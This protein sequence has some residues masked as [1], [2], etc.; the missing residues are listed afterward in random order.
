V[1]I[2]ESERSGIQGYRVAQIRAVF[3]LPQKAISTLF[4]A[5]VDPPK[6]LAYVEW[7]SEFRHNPEAN[8][9][10]YKIDRSFKD[11]K[12][13]AS[14]VRVSDIERSVFLFPKFGPIAPREWTNSNVLEQ[15]TMFYANPFTDRHSYITMY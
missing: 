12:R 14:I 9:L 10:M 4:Q 13:L 15:C 8:H 7:F 3:R 2:R 11:G 6:H 5:H 1:K